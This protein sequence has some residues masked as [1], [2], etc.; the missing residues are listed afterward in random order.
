MALR[1]RLDDLNKILYSLDRCLSIRISLVFLAV[2]F[3]P[4]ICLALASGVVQPAAIRGA[5]KV[6]KV[7]GK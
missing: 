4:C 1:L 2:L 7:G 5:L 3:L 6:A